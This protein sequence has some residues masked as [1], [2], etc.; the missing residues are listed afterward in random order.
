[1]FSKC[2]RAERIFE[3]QTITACGSAL[4]RPLRFLPESRTTS[5]STTPNGGL[6]SVEAVQTANL[7]AARMLNYDWKKQIGGIENGKFAD[8]MAV[9]GN[10][11][12][13]LTESERVKF[14]MR[15]GMVVRND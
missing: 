12:T 3:R 15:G 5:S 11:L 6:T 7:T 4:P 10:P 1:L 2:N 13:D 8:I 9:S 14:V